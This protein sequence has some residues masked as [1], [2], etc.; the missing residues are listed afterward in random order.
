[1]LVTA[2]VFDY[3]PYSIFLVVD[4]GMNVSFDDVHNHF[5]VS[6]CASRI[7]YNMILLEKLN[8][9][10]GEE[11]PH[12]DAIYARILLG[13]VDAACLTNKLEPRLSV[14]HPEVFLRLTRVD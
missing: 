1:M 5:A 9:E 8:H 11:R 2:G 7:K 14:E 3:L 4:E 6:M 10:L 13:L 12:L